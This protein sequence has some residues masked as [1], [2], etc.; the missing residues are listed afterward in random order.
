MGKLTKR[1]KKLHTH[2]IVDATHCTEL[3]ALIEV[4]GFFSKFCIPREEI[5]MD[6]QK[7][8]ELILV[9]LNRSI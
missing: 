4:V 5:K 8:V 3:R 2:S 7:G 6:F 9:L 1:K